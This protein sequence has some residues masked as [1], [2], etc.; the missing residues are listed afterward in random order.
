MKFITLAQSLGQL[1]AIAS[2]NQMTEVLADLFSRVT[3]Q[4]IDW[5]C[6]LVLGRLKPK[7]SGVEFNLAEKMMVR[8][9]SRAIGQS[10]AESLKLFKQTGDLGEVILKLKTSNSKLKI[11]KSL[12]IKDVYNSL[13]KIAEEAGEGSVERKLN[14]MAVLLSQLDPLSAK[15]VVRIPVKKLRLGFSDMT[16]LDALSW[17][18]TGDKSLRPELERA[19]SVSADIGRI[20]RVFKQQGLKGLKQIQVEVG[21]PIR[22]AL[23][24]RLPNAAKIVEKLEC[25]AVEPKYDGLR[26][27]LHLDKT[28]KVEL[29]EGLFKQQS[30]FIQIYSRN[31][32]NITHMFPEVVLAVEQLPVKQAIFDGEAIGVHPQTGKLLSFQETIQRRRKHNIKQMLSQVPIKVFIYDLLYLNGRAVFKQPFSQRRQLLEKILT[33]RQNGL[34]LTEQTKVNNVKQLRY[35]LDKYLQQGLEGIMCKKL[36]EPYQAGGRNFNWVKFKKN[37]EGKLVDTL[38][39]VVMGYYPGKGKRVGFGIGAFL[40]GVSDAETIKTV[41]KIGTGLTDDQWREMK[42]RCQQIRAPKCPNSYI[43]NKNLYPDFW[44]QPKIVVEIM[45]DEITKSPIH[46]AGLALRFPRLVR[47][48]DD[49]DIDQ[50]T[51]LKELKKLH[52]LQTSMLS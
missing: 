39:C 50:I 41:A 2:R 27:E 7:F 46:T 47:F 19:Y 21:I 37:T 4:E 9:L 1:E 17:M 31:L 10:E 42:K 3:Y 11:R 30:S 24:E 29:S 8:V 43:V 5:V 28:R 48:R 12:E 6:Y 15:Y 32:D 38:D 14:K 44:C 23:S 33:K 22:P 16:I 13:L 49:K 25:F 51:T 52:Q 18:Q 45:A 26:V 20:A 34:V 40:V 35:L 36:D